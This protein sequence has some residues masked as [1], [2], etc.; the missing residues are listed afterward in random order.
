[1]LVDRLEMAKNG[2]DASWRLTI[3]HVRVLLLSDN[4]NRLFIDIMWRL[5]VPMEDGCGG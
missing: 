2:Q 1:M 3:V 5:A 4:L